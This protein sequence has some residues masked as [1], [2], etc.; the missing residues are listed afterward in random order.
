MCR[1][2]LRIDWL[3]IQYI[4]TFLKL[5]HIH[6]II[7]HPFTRFGTFRVFSQRSSCCLA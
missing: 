6:G 2:G 4:H 5:I 3:P 1:S 7:R